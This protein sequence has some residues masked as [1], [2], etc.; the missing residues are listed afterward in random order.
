MAIK[1]LKGK[2]NYST[3]AF[4]FLKNQNAFTLR[5][6][7]K[8]FNAVNGKEEDFSNFRKKINILNKFIDNWFINKKERYG[9]YEN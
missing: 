3:L 6:L 2:I 9:R 4:N 1:R 5:E 7:Y 8:I